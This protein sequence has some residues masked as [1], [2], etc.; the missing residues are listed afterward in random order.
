MTPTEIKEIQDEAIFIHDRTC[1]VC[2]NENDRHLQVH[3]IDDNHDNNEIDNLAILC[4]NCHSDSQIEGGFFRKLGP[5]LVRKYRDEWLEIVENRGRGKGG[6]L[7]IEKAKRLSIP[8]NPIEQFISQFYEKHVLPL[9]STYFFE[10]YYVSSPGELNLVVINRDLTSDN[11]RR[12]KNIIRAY[13]QCILGEIA[14]LRS[15]KIASLYPSQALRSVFID[16]ETCL[17]VPTWGV[18]TD[19]V[20]FIIQIIGNEN[21][22]NK[23]IILTF[24]PFAYKIKDQ[25]KLVKF[26]SKIEEIIIK[27]IIGLK[28]EL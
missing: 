14:P 3:H 1:C 13:L 11:A 7:L 5:S 20:N 27:P 25:D 17:P 26:I 24:C 10:D 12:Y 16:E 19:G 4:Q 22:K 6:P 21:A 2:R 23:Q 28:L 15:L 8:T 9:N 18:P